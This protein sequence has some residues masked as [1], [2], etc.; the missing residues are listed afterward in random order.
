MRVGKV[1]ALDGGVA[2]WDPFLYQGWG[3]GQ[4]DGV[5]IYIRSL[6]DTVC[7]GIDTPY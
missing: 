6:S 4:N 5:A 1:L 2:A 7:W 3:E